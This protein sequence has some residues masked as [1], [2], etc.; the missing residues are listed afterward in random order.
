MNPL[1]HTHKHVVM[2]QPPVPQ[3]VVAALGDV[4]QSGEAEPHDAADEASRIIKRNH[5]LAAAIDASPVGVTIVDVLDPGHPVV[6]ANAAYWR[7]TGRSPDELV[8]PGDTAT[9]STSALSPDIL[10]QIVSA[11]AENRRL[12]IDLPLVGKDDAHLISATSM[13]PV[14]DAGGNCYAYIALHVDVTERRRRERLDRERQKLTAL[15]ELA[16]G[17]AHEINNLLQPII[18]LS[19]LALDRLDD[20]ADENESGDLET[21]LECSRAAREIVNKIL[22]FARKEGPVLSACDL[23]AEIR[24]ALL[25]VG[26]LLP[27]GIV[28]REAFA[29]GISGMATI[30]AGELTQVLTNL[31]VN[32]A[33]AMGGHG[34]VTMRLTRAKLSAA[35]SAAF[36]LRSGEYF[37]LSVSDT[38]GG[39]EAAVAARLFDPFFATKPIGQGT[40]LGLSVAYGIL[41]S[42][43]GAISVDSAVGR[44]TNFVLHIPVT[45]Q[46][47]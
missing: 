41:R 2:P 5:L 12:D 23:P 16:G 34:T 29:D 7:M 28:L 46:K 11:V 27:V 3:H 22:V 32:A 6:F 40:G 37:A 17:V 20:A 47:A 18:S 33:H 9:I 1:P 31:A 42:W 39:M 25:L 15:G 45:S 30:N 43:G 24:T 14:F 38:G 44:G 13:A 10:K 19:Q 35:A 26:A 4:C 8:L 36:E 21:V